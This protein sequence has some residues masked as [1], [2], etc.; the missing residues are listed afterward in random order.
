VTRSNWVCSTDY[1]G[2]DFLL[3]VSEPYFARHGTIETDMLYSCLTNLTTLTHVFTAAP[4][5]DNAS[6]GP[7]RFWWQIL[8]RI[9]PVLAS[10]RLT[11]SRTGNQIDLVSLWLHLNDRMEW[12]HEGLIGNSVGQTDSNLRIFSIASG[13]QRHLCVFTRMHESNLTIKGSTP[14][15]G[16]DT[17]KWRR[18]SWIHSVHVAIACLT[19]G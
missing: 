18:W 6:I 13:L 19:L 1:L 11:R 2:Y 15:F 5:V 9:E 10:A 3:T 4:P 7:D 14:S 12:Q 17:Q 16:Y 8:N